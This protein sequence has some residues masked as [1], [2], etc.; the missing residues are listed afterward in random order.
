MILS[1]QTF[2]ILQG[3]A[4]WTRIR[5]NLSE[6]PLEMRHLLFDFQ[7]LRQAGTAGR[8]PGSNFLLVE[9]F[10]VREQRANCVAVLQMF[11]A[12]FGQLPP[13]SFILPL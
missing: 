3:G 5:D 2:R 1:E 13:K 7:K 6:A 8:N 10:A 12:S 4:E 9:E 11:I